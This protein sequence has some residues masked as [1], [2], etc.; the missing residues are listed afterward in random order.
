VAREAQRVDEDPHDSTGPGDTAVDQDGTALR[1]EAVGH[2]HAAA[3]ASALVPRPAGT[4][5]PVAA[6]R[7]VRA[8]GSTPEPPLLPDPAVTAQALALCVAEILTG[9][10][11]VESIARWITE[12]VQRHLHQRAAFAARARSASP[13][14]NRRP[15]IRVGTV[16][17]SRPRDGVAEASVVVHTR[18]RARAVA[19][20]LEERA[21]RWRA[22][23]IG[24]L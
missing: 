10:R 9:A 20:R 7:S 19:I 17:V 18:S 6:D 15:S 11:D 14:R 8:D 1:V 5:A 2:D 24:M 16:V 12:D 21:G 13:H 3:A 4:D 23:A 22:T